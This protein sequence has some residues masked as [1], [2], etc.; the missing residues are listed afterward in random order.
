MQELFCTDKRD[1]FADKRDSFEG[2][3]P[4]ALMVIR[5]QSKQLGGPSCVCELKRNFESCRGRFVTPKKLFSK[6]ESMLG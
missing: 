6:R 4:L 2:K 5:C 3:L 1:S